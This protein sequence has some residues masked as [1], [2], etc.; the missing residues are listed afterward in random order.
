MM[1]SA[2]LLLIMFLAYLFFC[3]KRIM[4]YLHIF[5][6]DEYD[7]GRFLRWITTNRVFDRYLSVALFI[8]GLLWLVLPSVLSLL[9][10]F[11]CFTVIGVLEKDPRRSAKKKLVMTARAKR[12]MF[13]S[14]VIMALMGL[15]WFV[16][17]LPWIWILNV[18]IVPFSLMVVTLALSPFEARTQKKY[19]QEAHDK[20]R[21]L[22]PF[23]I[24]I[25]GSFG[26]TSVK[27]ILGHILKTHAPTL[28]TPGSVNTPMGITRIIR[29]RLDDSHQYFVAEMG[30]YGPGSVKRLCDLAPPKLGI[31][32]AIGHAHYERFGSLETV[33]EAKSELSQA[34]IADG[35]KMIVHENVLNFPFS[36]ELR[37]KHPENFIVCGPSYEDGLRI[38]NVE[39][40]PDGIKTR[41][42]WQGAT[43]VLALPLY[44][45]HH[46]H[47]AALAFAAAVTLGLEPDNVITALKSTPQIQHRL[48]VKKQPD[49][50]ALIDDAFNSNPSGFRAALDVLKNLKGGR[51]ILITPGMAELGAAHDDEH[52]AVGRHAGETC[53]VAIIVLPERVRA[54]IDG[55][56][57]S[58][59][60][61]TLIEVRSFQEASAWLDKNRQPGDVVLIENDLP[62]I[63]EA[64]PKI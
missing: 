40:T 47:N 17:P 20:L 37:D 32:T 41:I 14:L 18:Q 46:G 59:G 62:D 13:L 56:K 54:F 43:Y 51:K 3:A 52:R 28:I 27:H 48:E 34:V 38:E 45:L 57:M 55:F 7:N 58:G 50:G 30:A 29:Q 9:I 61:K 33:A 24:G 39:Q 25:T 19:W 4:T 10:I 11:L 8:A 5:Q 63:Y 2:P 21:A 1:L 36:K 26:K 53:D 44:G 16:V 12:I 6:Q 31:I 64:I 15:W 49:G 60:D 23:I 22:N 35:G 42:I